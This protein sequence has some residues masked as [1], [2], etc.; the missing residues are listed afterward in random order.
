MPRQRKVKI[1]LNVAPALAARYKALGE[2]YGVPRS[3]LY[4]CALERGYRSAA[5]WCQR[6]MSLYDSALPDGGLA[7][8]AAALPPSGAELSRSEAAEALGRYAAALAAEDVGVGMDAFHAMLS[9][10]AAVLG[11][12]PAT[13]GAI[14]GDV[15][16]RH[17]PGSST[18]EGVGPRSPAAPVDGQ[19]FDAGGAAASGE[20]DTPVPVHV[21]SGGASG[22]LVDLD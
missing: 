9:A 2:R 22:D 11:L 10:Q 1:M 12:T 20:D 13:S 7:D 16:A 14:I 4:R 18:V 17:F 3:E 15:V 19:L 6:S 8:Q 5:D 21:D